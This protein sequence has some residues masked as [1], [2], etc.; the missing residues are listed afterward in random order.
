[1]EEIDNF[2]MNAE[3]ILWPTIEDDIEPD[4]EDLDAIEDE[5][6]DLG[7]SDAFDDWRDDS[8][9]YDDGSALESVYGPND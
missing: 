8:S 5:D 3:E 9:N 1:M 4:D 6:D 2:D 7:G